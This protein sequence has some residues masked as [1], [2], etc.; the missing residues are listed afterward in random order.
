MVNVRFARLKKEPVTF[1]KKQLMRW[2]LIAK[3]N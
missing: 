1:K 3:E 2:L